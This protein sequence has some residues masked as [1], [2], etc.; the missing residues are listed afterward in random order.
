MNSVAKDNT[1]YLLTVNVAEFGL[2]E[3]VEAKNELSDALDDLTFQLSL[4]PG[5]FQGTDYQTWFKKALY[6]KN[7]IASAYRKFKARVVEL[8]RESALGQL[9][10]QVLSY[11]DYIDE[12]SEEFDILYNAAL[13]IPK[14]VK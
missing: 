6:K 2:E 14:Y 5:E 3:A 12:R 10:S 7:R 8:Q 11:L 4:P 13:N 1:N 9:A